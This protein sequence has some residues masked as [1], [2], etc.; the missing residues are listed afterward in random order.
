MIGLDYGVLKKL[1]ERGGIVDKVEHISLHRFVALKFT[2]GAFRKDSHV[3]ARFPRG[4]GGIGVESS[5][6]HSK[7]S[8]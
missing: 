1:E 6:F 5:L 2:P 8:P 3:L 4:K 7:S